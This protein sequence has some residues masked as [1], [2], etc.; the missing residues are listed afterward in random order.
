M[1]KVEPRTNLDDI[2]DGWTML[3]AL[4]ERARRLSALPD[5]GVSMLVDELSSASPI[6]QAH[7]RELVRQTLSKY[8]YVHA[9]AET[10]ILTDHGYNREFMRRATWKFLPELFDDDDI[11]HVLDDALKSYGGWLAD[12]SP[13]GWARVV[14]YFVAEDDVGG[15]IHDDVAAAIRGLAQRAGALGIDEELSE[16]LHDVE[17][18]DSPFL[19]LSETAHFFVE[20]HRQHQGD[21]ETLFVLNERVQECREIIRNFRAQKL[22]YGTSLRLT[23]LSR[24]ILQQLERIE[25]LAHVVRPD[26]RDD[27]V[28][29][30]SLA[31]NTLLTAHKRHRSLRTWFWES[32]DLLAFQLTELA[33]KKGGKYITASRSG[34]ISFL[35]AAMRGGAIVAVFAVIKLLIQKLQ[36]PLALEAVAFS[37]NYAV[38]FVAIYLTGS[39]L[40]T[41]QPAVTAS[42]IAQ[43][44]D[45]AQGED[46]QLQGVVDMVMLVWRSQFISFVG[47]LLCAFPFAWL[48]AFTADNLLGKPLANPSKALY[49][50]NSIHPWASA[51]LYYAAVAG[52]F[53][54][55]AGF[56][57]GAVNNAVIHSRIGLRVQLAPGLNR[58]RG[59][60]SRLSS[61]IQ[62]HAGMVAGNIALGFFLG[63]AGL[64]GTLF[65]V[66]FD[67]RH[68]AFSSAHFGVAVFS[69]PSA[70]TY[71]VALF[72]MLG[73]AGIGF[74]NFL[75]SFGL[76]L[77]TTLRS[78]GV[79]FLRGRLLAF[80]VWQ[81]VRHRPASW[82]FP[83]ESDLEPQAE[84]V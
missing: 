82:L 10:G 43:R 77:L 80:M 70:V 9:F 28:L 63:C 71:D 72:S 53:L 24:R 4:L 18:Y 58:I 84:S 15:I 21:K 79:T 41:K 64:I 73:V 42:A 19:D 14:D 68:I 52:V 1:S 3:S 39:I 26:N 78:R 76:T 47:N 46:A 16:K 8:R 62:D 22:K 33:A 49:L 34:Y 55:I 35:W 7:V 30:L 37:L 23:T 67:I 17:D 50:L 61:F 25:L 59:M 13:I 66:P 29:N 11:R 74:V 31:L 2:Q 69:M 38:C 6:L 45:E 5:E 51:A 48:I 27:L 36:L 65:G 54:F 81:D 83:M 56:L 57:T 20:S 32:T 75:V 60:S 12:I 40:A 44:M